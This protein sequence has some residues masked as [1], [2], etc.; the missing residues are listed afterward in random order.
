MAINVTFLQTLQPE[1]SEVLFVS[2]AKLAEAEAKY[3]H[4]TEVKKTLYFF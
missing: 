3:N 2:E 1:L 4:R